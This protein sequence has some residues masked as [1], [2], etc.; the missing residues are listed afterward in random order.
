MID[1]YVPIVEKHAL[2]L[3]PA[4]AMVAAVPLGRL[5]HYRWGKVMVVTI[6]ALVLWQALV[7]GLDVIVFQ[8]VQE[9]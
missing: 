5:T 3:L 4:L 1:Y 6:I 2:H 9:K 7:L 8:Y